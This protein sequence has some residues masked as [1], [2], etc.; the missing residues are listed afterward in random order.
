MYAICTVL[1]IALLILYPKVGS[2]VAIAIMGLNYGAEVD[3]TFALCKPGLVLIPDMKQIYPVGFNT[4]PRNSLGAQQYTANR[5][6]FTF[7]AKI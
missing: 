7:L 1:I 5:S 3:Q 4:Q 6:D 2:Q